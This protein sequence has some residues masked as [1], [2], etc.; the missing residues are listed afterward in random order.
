MLSGFLRLFCC[1][2]I[3][4]VYA[5]PDR[6]LCFSER[7]PGPFA[8]SLVLMR[9]LRRRRRV[10]PPHLPMVFA[11]SKFF[12]PPL[13]AP[14]KKKVWKEVN[15]PD[16]CSQ[17]RASYFPQRN[18][19][20]GEDNRSHLLEDHRSGDGAEFRAHETKLHTFIFRGSFDDRSKQ[21]GWQR[22]H[23]DPWSLVRYGAF[24]QG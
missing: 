13:P 10:L 14:F 2:T 11:P 19:M 7:L 9:I 21:F 23:R 22:E 24:E 18:H 20:H 4:F 1:S 16:V 17:S 5:T 3:C 8:M 6:C 15:T 12:L